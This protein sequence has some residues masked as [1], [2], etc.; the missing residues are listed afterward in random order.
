VSEDFDALD[1]MFTLGTAT[2]ID[3]VGDTFDR[4]L[5]SFL[6]G[7]GTDIPSTFGSRDTDAF[8]SGGGPS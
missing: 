7:I 5:F 3:L 8:G 1:T 2:H 4:V 6:Y